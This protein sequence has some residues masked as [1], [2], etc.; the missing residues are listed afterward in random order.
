MTSAGVLVTF[1]EYRFEAPERDAAEQGE[2]VGG[3][4]SGRSG[5]QNCPQTAAIQTAWVPTL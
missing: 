4:P 2:K 1:I 5:R 3:M